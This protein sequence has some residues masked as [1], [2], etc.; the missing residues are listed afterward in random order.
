MGLVYRSSSENLGINLKSS[1]TLYRDGTVVL[2]TFN[3]VRWPLTQQRFKLALWV[4]SQRLRISSGPSNCMTIILPFHSSFPCLW[5]NI[6]FHIWN[7]HTKQT[8]LKFM[9]ASLPIFHGIVSSVTY[10]GAWSSF[11]ASFFTK[12]SLQ[13]VYVF[14]ST[15]TPSHFLVLLLFLPYDLVLMMDLM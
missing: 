4:C 3:R 6:R 5:K 11:Y 2:L 9:L 15:Y 7:Y 14:H 1:Q 13:G 12:S 10:T 8:E